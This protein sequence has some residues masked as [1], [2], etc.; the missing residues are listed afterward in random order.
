MTYLSAQRFKEIADINY[1][2]GSLPSVAL[3]YAKGE[4][5][6]ECLLSMDENG[7]YILITG[8]GDVAITNDYLPLMKGS[9]KYWFAQNCVVDHPNIETFPYGL[10]SEDGVGFL[11]QEINMMKTLQIDRGYKNS[12]LI[13]HGVPPNCMVHYKE[14]G[15]SI[16]YM[17]DKKYCDILM[18]GN[19]VNYVPREKVYLEMMSH[20]YMISTIGMGFDCMRTWESIYLGTIPICKRYPFN[21]TFTDM[22]IAFVNDWSDINEQWL[23]DNLSVR[24]KSSERCYF[25]YWEKKIVE[26]CY[27]FD[28]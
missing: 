13:C 1:T 16:K 22:P 19:P 14:R 15:D 27:K 26:R 23:E 9:L 12:V 18:D 4:Y 2:G 3:I 8:G 25:E 21:K 17:S 20:D 10:A 11:D 6:R 28:V 24:N 5:A 7:R